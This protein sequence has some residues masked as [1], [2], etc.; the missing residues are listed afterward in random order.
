M[1][2]S[3]GTGGPP[4]PENSEATAKALHFVDINKLILINEGLGP[5]TC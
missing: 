5:A 2:S 4:H 1:T 3:V